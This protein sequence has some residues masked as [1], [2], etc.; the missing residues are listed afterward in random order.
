MR[1]LLLILFTLPVI[2]FASEVKTIL[3][4][5]DSLTEGYGI[6]K[7]HA[8]PEKI[9]QLLKEK[10]IETKILNGGVSGSTTASGKSRL[11]WF[12]RA[13]PE[14]MVLAL[15]A[16]DGLRGIKVSESTKNLKEIIELGRKN[17][18]KIL[19]CGMQVPPNYGESYA[20]DFRKMFNELAKEYKLEYMPFLLK[21]V[22]GK[23]ELNISDGVHPNEKGH[24]ILAKNIL[25]YLEK[26]L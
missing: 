17:N 6:Q 21:D 3:F 23:K 19:L 11:K 1:N 4:L 13:K 12:L 20:K 2:S 18:L 14:I 22:A 26:L 7:V 24:K 5:G 16:N 9:K 15:G 10:K 8:Y 25:S